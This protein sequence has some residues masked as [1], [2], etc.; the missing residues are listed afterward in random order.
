MSA[1]GAPDAP[2]RS[3]VRLSLSEKAE[4][5]RLLRLGAS[6]RQMQTRFSCSRRCIF[7]IKKKGDLILRQAEQSRSWQLK[8]SNKPMYPIIEK[9][10]YQWMQ[11]A[12]SAKLH[13]NGTTLFA[14]ALKIRDSLVKEEANPVRKAALEKFGASQS[15]ICS[16][17]SRSTRRSAT[18]QGKP[19]AVKIAEVAGGIAKLRTVLQ[20]YKPEFIFSVEKTNMFYK[21]FP[22]RTYVRPCEKENIIRCATQMGPQDR[23]TSFVCTNAT[24]TLKVP[25]AIIGKSASPACFR[26]EAPPVSYFSQKNAWSDIVIFQK[27]FNLCFLPFI[28][29]QTS[30]PVA[31]IMDHW[32]PHGADLFDYKQQ[33][34]IHTLPTNS[35]SIHRPMGMGV[36]ATFKLQYRRH[37]LSRIKANIKERRAL[38]EAAGTLREDMRGLNE[39]HDPHMLNVAQLVKQAWDEIPERTIARCWVKADILPHAVESTLEAQYGRMPKGEIQDVEHRTQMAAL[40]DVFRELKTSAHPSCDISEKLMYIDASDLQHWVSTEDAVDVKNAMANDAFT[41]FEQ[42]FKNAAEAEAPSKEVVEEETVTKKITSLA[43]IAA[44][45]KEAEAYA[46]KAGVP[47]ASDA[48]RR[49]KRALSDVFEK[50][51]KK[52]KT[53]K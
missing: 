34:T 23:V 11:I 49:A 38:R 36:I 42:N 39:G 17:V 45:F 47:A 10:L 20:D 19:G 53:S 9:K 28:R 14:K 4:M 12:R 32:G 33:V 8:S 31:L 29:A 43:E 48:L 24:G 50:Q 51:N 27:W 41:E 30:E 44:A 35:A 25:M 5:V 22:R 3:R 15:W 21:L 13:V 26:K 40:R 18:L 46:E 52:T 37:L 6:A 16:F 2:R 7:D 1:A